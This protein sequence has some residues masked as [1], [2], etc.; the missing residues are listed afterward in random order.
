MRVIDVARR[1]HVSPDMIRGLERDKK[2]PPVPRDYNGHRRF[3]TD[4]IDRILQVLFPNR[5]DAP[6]APRLFPRTGRR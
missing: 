6:P 2:I 5:E 3:R 4:D 1:F